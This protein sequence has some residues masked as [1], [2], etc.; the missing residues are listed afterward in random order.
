MKS[1]SSLNEL[2]QAIVWSGAASFLTL[3]ILAK[4]SIFSLI[5]AV[6]TYLFLLKVWINLWNIAWMPLGVVLASFLTAVAIFFCVFLIFGSLHLSSYIE[7]RVEKVKEELSEDPSWRRSGLLDAWLARVS[8][9]N[10]RV[11]PDQGANFIEIRNVDEFKKLVESQADAARRSILSQDVFKSWQIHDDQPVDL[12]D[13]PNLP[14]PPSFPKDI[15]ADNN[16]ATKALEHYVNMFRNKLMASV[17][18]M[19]GRVPWII[20][21]VGTAFLMGTLVGVAVGAY[22]NVKA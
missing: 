9:S 16:W 8:R 4:A 20:I 10:E 21:T 3:D 6:L 2:L 5:A 12:R 17:R 22:K 13:F 15:C 7:D 14:S 18:E 1:M 19:A 11:T